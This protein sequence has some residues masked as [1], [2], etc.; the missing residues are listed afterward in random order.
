MSARINAIARQ[1]ATLKTQIKILNN[2]VTQN[3]I[4]KTNA[5]LRLKRVTELFHA[6]EKLHEELAEIDE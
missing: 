4:D 2:L 3:E 6:Y 5:T 1:R